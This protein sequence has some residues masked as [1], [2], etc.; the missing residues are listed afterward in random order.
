MN[1]NSGPYKILIV[2]SN[3]ED[4]LA[5]LKMIQKRFNFPTVVHVL[6]IERARH[7]LAKSFFDIILFDISF[8]AREGEELVRELA[9]IAD[10]SKVI[11]LCSSEYKHLEFEI[12]PLGVADYLI[13]EKINSRLVFKSITHAIQRN[14]ILLSLRETQKQYDELFHLS[15]LPMWIYNVE[16]LQ[17][18]TVNRAAIR[19]YGY[20]RKEFEKMT[21]REIRPQEDVDLMEKAV[22]IVK[23]HEWLFTSGTYRHQKKNGEIIIVEI[24]SN[25][26]YLDNVKYELVLANDITE[27]LRHINVIEEKNKALKE[28]AF[29]QSHIVRAPLA[30]IMGLL[31]HV[32]DMDFTSGEGAPFLQHILTCSKQLDESIREIVGKASR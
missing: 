12:L 31:H 9:K 18:R 10:I 8:R 21:L 14:K 25:I 16:T 2:E 3:T 15:P 19:Q 24:V 26:I 22:E 7:E 4:Y 11:I 17:F 29:M 6:D 30:N 20:T 5:I 1:V 23:G 28:I 13:K 32:K 27:Q